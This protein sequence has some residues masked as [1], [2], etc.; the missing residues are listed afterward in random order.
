M[1]SVIL[2][3]FGAVIMLMGWYDDRPDNVTRGTWILGTGI[4]MGALLLALGSLGYTIPETSFKPVAPDLEGATDLGGF[5]Q[6]LKDNGVKVGVVSQFGIY[7]I[8][9]LIAVMTSIADLTKYA[10]NLVGAALTGTSSIFGV[11]IG[12]LSSIAYG[13]YVYFAMHE[14]AN[15][16]KRISNMGGSDLS[17][18]GIPI[19]LIIR[20]ALPL[21]FLTPS[22]LQAM[23][24]LTANIASSTLSTVTASSITFT[25]GTTATTASSITFTGGT[26]ATTATAG[27]NATQ[28]SVE[29]AR[30]IS[31]MPFIS[32]LIFTAL[33]ALSFFMG[34]FSMGKIAAIGI[35][36]GIR[37]IGY[38]I[39]I[40]V[41]I[42]SFA[43]EDYQDIGKGM[44]KGFLGSALQ[45]AFVI[46]SIQ[47]TLILSSALLN[48]LFK[49]SYSFS[50]IMIGVGIVSAGILAAAEEGFNL[51]KELIR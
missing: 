31:G 1:I 38:A 40:P 36:I 19:Q 39:A 22:F 51:S 18:F 21:I 11:T 24:G 2:I 14:I 35:S 30:S 17:S 44:I 20:L 10:I 6:L 33:C 8:Y 49:N 13:L 27:F 50:N 41:G 29:M 28:I 45:G 34:M 16:Y 23:T 32:E 9:V 43:S 4:A 25:G 26:T 37:L 15:Q 7:L 47:L 5:K 46:L 42:A 3:V 12:V 48:A